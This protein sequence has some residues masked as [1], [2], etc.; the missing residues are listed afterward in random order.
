MVKNNYRL[1]RQHLLVTTSS[2]YN[3]IREKT[4]KLKIITEHLNNYLC[5]IYE[6]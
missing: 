6:L 5:L 1:T 2:R 4:L 3:A